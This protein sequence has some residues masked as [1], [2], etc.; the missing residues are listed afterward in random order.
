MKVAMTANASP[1]VALMRELFGDVSDFIAEKRIDADKVRKY[2]EMLQLLEERRD[3]WA[4]NKEMSPID[5]LKIYGAY[6]TVYNTLYGVADALDL[7]I[8][9]HEN[10]KAAK[11]VYSIL[12]DAME[13]LPKLEEVHNKQNK[14]QIPTGLIGEIFDET[15]ILR[16]QAIS[17][18]L[19]QAGEVQ[20]RTELIK[21]LIGEIEQAE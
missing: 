15:R 10:P 8:K 12:K 17:K 19:I 14:S 18:R 7:G 2:G 3:H 20:N 1:I 9:R 16:K 4:L 11:E 13:L 6:S 5:S 21:E